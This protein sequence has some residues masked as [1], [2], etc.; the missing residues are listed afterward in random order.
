MPAARP[1]RIRQLVRDPPRMDA[2]RARLEPARS[3]LPLLDALLDEIEHEI[4]VG[5]GI[6]AGALAY[7]LFL[8][9]LPLAFFLVSALGLAA[10]ALDTAP[11]TIGKDV[12]LVGLVTNEVAATAERGSGV[13]VALGS[14]VVL[15]YATRVLHRAVAIVH[16]LAWERS[17][18]SARART[19][20]LPLFALGVAGQLTLALLAGAVRAQTSI[21]GVL[22]LVAYAVGSAGLWLG[23][24]LRL[25]HADARWTDLWPGSLLFG[26]GILAVSAFNTYLLS[27]IHTARASTYGTLGAAAAVLLSLFL[28]GRIVVSAAVLNA[29]LYGRG[30]HAQGT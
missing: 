4:D 30:K 25:P 20:S 23:M 18:T 6:L 21:G 19:G 15:A 5:G 26:V 2:V 12:G 14:L 17:A 27:S 29:T 22:A 10:D 11:R 9:F 1:G 28:I 13:W 7:R 3:R 8:F 16:A 24:S